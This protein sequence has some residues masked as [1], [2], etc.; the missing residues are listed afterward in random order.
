MTEQ[1]DDRRLRTEPR[2]IAEVL[3]GVAPMGD[4]RRFAV[5]DLTPDEE[6]EF[7]RILE[8]A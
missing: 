1:S 4:L 3:E 2:T 5:D 7:F 8:E 6:D